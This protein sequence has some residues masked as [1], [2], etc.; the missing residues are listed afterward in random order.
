MR[1]IEE[2]VM[3]LRD[4]NGLTEAEFLAAYRPG[5]YARPSVTVDVLIFAKDSATLKLLMI[6]RGGHP[7]LGMWALPGGF[8]NPEE[9]TDCAAMRELREETHIDGL[10]LTP[11]GL[12]SDP[13]RDPRTW[14]MSQAYVCLTGNDRLNVQADDDADDAKWFTVDWQK[15][16]GGIAVSLQSADIH[17]SAE[18]TFTE[19]AT[20][21]GIVRTFAIIQNDGIAFD[22]AKMIASAL[23]KMSDCALL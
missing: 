17:L 14:T 12:F 9:N 3:E 5:N 15:E 16:E 8:T 6:R 22:H 19:E 4:K 18:L 23:C 10:R 7:C 1:R 2:S 20:P 11:L 13:H 21:L